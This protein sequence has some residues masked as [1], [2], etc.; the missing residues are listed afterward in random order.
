MEDK[1]KQVKIKTDHFEAT[2][3]MAQRTFT[4][5]GDFRTREVFKVPDN[6]YS[7]PMLEAF[8]DELYCL[9]IK[10]REMMPIIKQGQEE[11]EGIPW[12]TDASTS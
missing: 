10:I 5:F 12:P 3:D 1:V 6:P 9:E 2:V 4:I 8:H 11:E 7:G